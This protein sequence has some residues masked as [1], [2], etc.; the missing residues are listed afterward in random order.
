MPVATLETR[1]IRS[2]DR[3]R[4]R[5]AERDAFLLI[6]R[7][8][9]DLRTQVADSLKPAGL[10]TAQYDVLRILR[11]AGGVGLACSD[12]S[13]RLVEHDPDVTRLLDRIEASGWVERS[14]DTRD[15]RV[16]RV[17]ITAGGLELLATLDAQVASL[18]ARQ[19]AQLAR[20]EVEA[21]VSLLERLRS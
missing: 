13:E 6:E 9:N 14:R 19:F 16:V 5:K 7:T 21:L 4:S 15:R 3:R 18:H 20:D 11:D 2:H 12:V 10:S 17:R 8:A 1:K